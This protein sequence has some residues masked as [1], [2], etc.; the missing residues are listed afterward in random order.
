[1]KGSDRVFKTAKLFAFKLFCK[2]FF[3]LFVELKLL[4][5]K[6]IFS[7]AKLEVVCYRKIPEFLNDRKMLVA[8]IKKYAQQDSVDMAMAL[9]EGRLGHH[10]KTSIYLQFW[11]TA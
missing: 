2:F 10:F 5:L 7:I 6:S 1:M 11:F 8:W 4:P 3:Q 9:I